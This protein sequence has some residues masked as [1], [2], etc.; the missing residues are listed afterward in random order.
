MFFL[1][2]RFLFSTRKQQ[3][4]LHD[5]E[6]GEAPLATFLFDRS[7]RASKLH[8]KV[9]VDLDDLWLI[10]NDSLHNPSSDA[11]ESIA[12]LSR[13]LLLGPSISILTQ[14]LSPESSL[15]SGEG[16]GSPALPPRPVPEGSVELI[17]CL[18]A[19]S[20]AKLVRLN[21]STRSSR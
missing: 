13:R 2:S 5:R 18:L 12:L 19:P 11:R 10:P 7:Q 16:G 20:A 1:S 8:E 4:L 14:P 9:G 15:G 3:K 17:R 6:G 21:A